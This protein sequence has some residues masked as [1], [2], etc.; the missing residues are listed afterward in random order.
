[1]RP[2][3]WHPSPDCTFNHLAS[4]ASNMNFVKVQ[5][6]PVSIWNPTWNSHQIPVPTRW[7]TS[8]IFSLDLQHYQPQIE[9]K[10]NF[11]KNLK[12][13][14]SQLNYIWFEVS[15]M[16]YHVGIGLQKSMAS[17]SLQNKI[18]NIPIMMHLVGKPRPNAIQLC[19][20]FSD[21][22]K[23]E[24]ILTSNSLKN[25]EILN[26]QFTAELHLVWGL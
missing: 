2:F 8:K 20:E 3:Q 10:V 25:G 7:L 4:T 17:N 24:A 26:F 19:K 12:N 18:Q 16:V 22:S 21:S 5:I 23:F 9:V 11:L 13:L 15:K 6:S 14:S 1:M